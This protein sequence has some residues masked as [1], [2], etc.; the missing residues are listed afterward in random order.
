MVNWRAVAPSDEAWDETLA[1]IPGAN[2]FMSIVSCGST[3]AA[4][5]VGSNSR[6]YIIALRNSSLLAIRCVNS[7]APPGPVSTAAQRSAAN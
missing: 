2:A 6:K 3:P 7:A 4:P 1:R 5:V